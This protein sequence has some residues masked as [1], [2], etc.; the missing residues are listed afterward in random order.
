MK[1]EIFT[2]MKSLQQPRRIW[3]EFH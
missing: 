2:G 1:F 3:L